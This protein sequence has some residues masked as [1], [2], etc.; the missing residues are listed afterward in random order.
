MEQKIR[1]IPKL[2]IK[3]PNVVKG[4]HLE[5]LRIVGN[6]KELAR[7][8]YKQG[9]D[10][11]FYVD[12]VAS[13]YGR[14]NMVEIVD[15]ASKEIFI[16]L[17]VGGGVRNIDDINKLLRSGADKV[18]INSSAIKN[19]KLIINAVKRFGSANIVVSIEAKKIGNSKWEAYIE[20]GREKTGK[21]V[22]EWAKK[23]ESLGVG[24]IIVTSIDKEGTKR[25]FDIRLIKE[26]CANVKIPVIA[27]GGAGRIED[28]IECA[29]TGVDGICFASV[30][31]YNLFEISEI[32]KALL[33]KGFN[34]R[35]KNE[36]S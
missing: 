2:D 19:P 11:I 4:I 17:S 31:H 32:K 22:I 30:L 18:T 9:A 14:N 27:C 26:I 34:V 1:I 29:K 28:I 20:N 10:E 24:E 13:L 35:Y 12:I 7:K 23:V 3:G 25:G 16:P 8:Y 36:K 33:E 21:D 5:G 6:P 15:S